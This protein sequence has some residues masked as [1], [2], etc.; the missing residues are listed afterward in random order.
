M[1]TDIHEIQIACFRL[2]DDLY[3]AD[4]M[5]IKEIIRPQRLT[6]LP[7]SPSFVKGV[8][9]LRGTVI[10][11]IDLRER[12]DFPVRTHDKNTRLLIVT[13]GRQLLGLE[14]DEVTEVITVHVKDIK[15]PPQVVNGV[16]SEYLVGVCLAKE[17][18]IMLLN[19]DK[20]LTDHES[21]ELKTMTTESR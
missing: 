20:I 18:L 8:L 7:K 4:I 13:V 19:L 21:G 14:V 10:P 15:S 9:N 17:S 2:G 11:V 16:R 1:N 3:A 12:F 6:A 5:R